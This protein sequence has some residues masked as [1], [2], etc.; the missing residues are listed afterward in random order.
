[1]SL[2]DKI[3]DSVLLYQ[4]DCLELMKD[5]P[6]GSV[7]LVLTDPPYG[8]TACK[9]DSVIP[10]SDMWSQLLRI[11]KDDAAI[12]F[13][14]SQPFT[15]FL[16]VSNPNIFRYEWIYQK[17]AGSNFAQ[18]RRQPM[19]EHESILVFSKKPSRYFPIKEE[20]RGNEV[21]KTRSAAR[22]DSLF[23]SDKGEV[24]G[25]IQRDRDTRNYGEL[26]YPSTVQLFNNR[27]PSDRGLHPTQKPI[28]LMEYFVTTYTRP[29][30]VVLDFAMG[31][32]STGVACVNTNRNF[33]GIELDDNYYGIAKKRIE[34][35]TD[36][37]QIKM[38]AV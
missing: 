14:S 1:M 4:G 21:G 23:N 16:V 31:S 32:G 10:I 6:D 5:I 9:W 26:R 34:E 2:I 25:S 15:S 33:I 38:D 36:A 19:K 12:V 37:Q 11:A 7:D 27:K 18:V 8:T 20:R 24:Y 3:G 29:N 30:E 35:A 17:T 28:S 22:K 13:T